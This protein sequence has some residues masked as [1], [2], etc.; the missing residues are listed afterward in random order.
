M[1]SVF[2]LSSRRFLAN[3]GSV[4]LLF[5]GQQPRQAT[6][7][8]PPCTSA[9]EPCDLKQE[10]ATTLDSLMAEE[11]DGGMA[12]DGDKDQEEEGT[13][14][15][16]RESQELDW[17]EL[18]AQLFHILLELEETREVS[19]RYQEDYLEL[20]GESHHSQRQLTAVFACLRG[21]CLRLPGR[22]L[23]CWGDC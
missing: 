5:V 1:D 9:D 3:Q 21:T 23:G 20:Q 15:K 17:E 11:K 18:R 14:E 10:R 6:I 19:L 2:C 7:I 13:E 12:A 8:T 4:F 16:G 22:W